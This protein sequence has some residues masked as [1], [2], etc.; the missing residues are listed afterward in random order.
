MANAKRTVEPAGLQSPQLT[1]GSVTSI[2]FPGSSA[3]N[4]STFG[5]GGATREITGP[6]YGDVGSSPPSPP[7][8]SPAASTPPAATA[9]SNGD[10]TAAMKLA[11]EKLLAIKGDNDTD[12]IKAYQE[13]LLK[14][15]G[16]ATLE[17]TNN[18][19]K[20]RGIWG[21]RTTALTEKLMTALAAKDAITPQEKLVFLEKGAAAAKTLAGAKE[22][23]KHVKF[24]AAMVQIVHNLVSTKACDRLKVDGKHGH[25][26]HEAAQNFDAIAA[27]ATAVLTSTAAPAAPAATTSHQVGGASIRSMREGGPTTAAP[28]TTQPA[29]AKPESHWYDFLMLK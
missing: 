11:K 19:N 8:G 25:E 22:D 18:I 12:G 23:P 21:P 14:V 17:Q 3:S 5:F 28:P 4:D 6:N 9:G 27:Q 29:P 26:T 1:S 15:P 16:L 10:A 2:T 13:A 24:G 7:P 20:D